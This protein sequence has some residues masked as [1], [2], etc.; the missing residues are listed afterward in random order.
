MI[1]F[2]NLSPLRVQKATVFTITFPF[3]VI[4]RVRHPRWFQTCQIE[5]KI[6]AAER[7]YTPAKNNLMQQRDLH[8]CPH[9]ANNLKYPGHCTSCQQSSHIAV[10][11]SPQRCVTKL[12]L[13]HSASPSILTLS[14]VPCFKCWKTNKSKT[15]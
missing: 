15:V 13:S 7:T 1:H 6:N 8:T 2:K 12:C 4:L 11:H 9:Q 3:F 10:L 5:E 14:N